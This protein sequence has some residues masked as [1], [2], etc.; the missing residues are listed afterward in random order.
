[1]DT[2]RIGIAGYGLYIPETVMTAEDIALATN[3]QWTAQ[4]VREKLGFDKKP[5][6]GPEDGTQEMGVKAGL[7]ALKRTGIDPDEIDLI[8]CMGEEYKEYDLTTSGIYIQ[9]KIG[10]KRAWS[11]DIQQRCNST[12]ACIK[13]AKDMMRADQDINTVMIVGGYRNGDFID[14][15]DPAVSFMFNLG[16][17]GSAIILKKGYDKNSILGSHI[18]TD[19]SMARDAGVEYGGTVNPVNKLPDDI[20]EDMRK[21][22]NKSLRLFDAKH[23]KDR[24]NEVSL[25]NWY[26][27]IDKALEKSGYTRKDLGYFNI[28][29]FKY[30]MFLAMLEE[31]GLT[32]EQSFYLRDYGHLGQV[33]QVVSMHEGL[34]TGR[35]KDGDIMAITA[36][37]IGY[38]WGATIVKWGPAD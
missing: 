6:P 1:M 28:L 24:L 30:S 9:E 38:V 36:A 10:A 15:T 7:D 33:D 17:G 11:I 19:G 29:H 22:G 35:L 20:V 8:L 26:L 25:P 34:Q 2:P 32:E 16:A 27:C 37:G 3:G 23:M 5:V 14:Y 13:I 31:L 21:R 12:V 4:A 18:V